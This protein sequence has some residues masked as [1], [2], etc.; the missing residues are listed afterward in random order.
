MG[1]TF[2]VDPI[3]HRRLENKGE[4]KQYLTENHHKA[5]ISREVFEKAQ[6]IRAKRNG[7][8]NQG[9][10]EKYSRQ[11]AFSC[12]LKCAFCGGNLS[13]RTWNSRTNFHKTIWQCV[14][15]T[16]HGKET[17]PYC[18]GIE[19]TL[20]EQAFVRS[21]NILCK[22]NSAIVENFIKRLET[23]LK[24][25]NNESKIKRLETEI[26]S[27]EEQ[28]SKLLDLFLQ[29]TVDKDTLESKQAELDEKLRIYLAKKATLIED[30]KL[31]EDIDSRIAGFRTAINTN[32]KLEC[33]DR[34]VFEC[35]ID[36]VIVGEKK[37]DGT[38]DPCIS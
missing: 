11:Y 27:I 23:S 18:K 30:K 20:I 6:E 37:E 31:Q 5:I 28:K 32:K 1:K 9:R 2:T 19:E 21:Y 12:M 15:A 3:T 33:F 22:E 8:R 7:N 26:R 36:R 25:S 4:A 35:I 14:S 38:I 24:P 17:C 29:D 13:R 16:K 34:A 10:A